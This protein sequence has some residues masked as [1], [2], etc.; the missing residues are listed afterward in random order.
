MNIYSDD[1]QSNEEGNGV[2]HALRGDGVRE[3]NLR[4]NKTQKDSH[5][6]FQHKPNLKFFPK[7]SLKQRIPYQP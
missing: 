4:N 6:K 2:P 7:A 5:I 3:Q 1:G